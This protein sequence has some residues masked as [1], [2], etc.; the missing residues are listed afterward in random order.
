VLTGP[1][2]SGDTLFE[3][4]NEGVMHAKYGPRPEVAAEL[5]EVVVVD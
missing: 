4:F 2:A 1:F 3:F 5:R